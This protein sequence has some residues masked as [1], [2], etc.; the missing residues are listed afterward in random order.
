MCNINIPL[1]KCAGYKIPLF[2]GGNDTV[3]NLEL[4]DIYVYWEI[5][6]QLKNK[7]N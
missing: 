3:D 7:I 1:D 2:I 4:S 5:C 6:S